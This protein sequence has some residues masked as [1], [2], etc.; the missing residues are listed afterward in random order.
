MLLVTVFLRRPVYLYNF[1]YKIINKNNFRKLIFKNISYNILISP[2][3]GPI[4]SKYIEYNNPY[5]Y[6]HRIILIREYVYAKM[7]D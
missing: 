4:K 3:E 7:D 6:K 1:R 5:I 2:E